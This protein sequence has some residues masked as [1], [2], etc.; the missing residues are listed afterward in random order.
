MKLKIR[1]IRRAKDI[2]Q[3]ELAKLSNVS[4]ATI[5]MLESG[6]LTDTTAGT[7]LK[8]ADALEVSVGD[9]FAPSKSSALDD[10]REE[11]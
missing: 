5:S 4:R 9:F 6:R 7:L 3:D 11:C 1:D 10:I 8:L 2:T